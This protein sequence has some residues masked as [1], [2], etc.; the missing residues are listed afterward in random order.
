[1]TTAPG[2]ALFTDAIP[3]LEAGREVRPDG[4]TL[5]LLGYCNSR[6]GNHEV[7]LYWYDRA[8]EAGFTSAGLYNDRGFSRLQFGPPGAA[9]ED[10]ES[11]SK[12]DPNLQAA[13]FNRAFF[14]FA[15][16]GPP[17]ASRF[18]DPFSPT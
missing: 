10:F 16:N 11:A 3:D 13:I 6:A 18:P 4:A 15:R 9:V 7:A 8:A 12:S 2:G 5:A 17:G 14:L 1:M